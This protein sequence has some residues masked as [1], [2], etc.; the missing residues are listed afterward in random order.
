VRAEREEGRPTD[1]HVRLPRRDLAELGEG[2]GRVRV[3]EHEDDL[4]LQPGARRLVV[5]ADDGLEGIG[6][7][8]LLEGLER[9]HLDRV[10][11]LGL[12]G[13]DDRLVL[14]LA[15]LGQALGEADHIGLGF[16]GP[17]ALGVVP[18]ELLVALEGRFGGLAQLL[19]GVAGPVL[20]VVDPGAFREVADDP[21]HGRLG[22]GPFFREDE[23]VGLFVGDGVLLLPRRVFGAGD[24]GRGE[25]DP[26]EEGEEDGGEPA[27]AISHG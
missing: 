21:V 3:A 8:A 6:V 14:G 9:G 4:I 13:L 5:E 17:V 23:L 24:R 25:P 2:L 18:D 7:A 22:G 12:E 26:D 1:L 11:V 15:R 19:L 27:F 16:I 20:G 10:L